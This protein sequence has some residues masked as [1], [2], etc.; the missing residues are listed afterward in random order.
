MR[1]HALRVITATALFAAVGGCGDPVSSGA[2]S[3]PAEPSYGLLSG[4]LTSVVQRLVPLRQNYVATATIGRA[5]G[6]IRIPEAGF[7]LTVPAGALSSPVTMRATAL[8]GTS[9]AYR[10]EP[11]GLV[12]Q[13]EPT[14]AQDLS[15]TGVVSQLLSIRLAGGYFADESTLTGGTVLVTEERP[16]TVDL[17]RLRMTFNIRHFSGYAATQRGGYLTSTGNRMGGKPAAK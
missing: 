17:L 1:T 14:I 15:L 9:V 8:A 10:L 16:A 3:T 2:R 11:H 12:F 5:G 4:V 6:T 7:T 13:Q